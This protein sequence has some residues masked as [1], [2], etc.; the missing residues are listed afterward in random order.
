MCIQS[1]V[2]VSMLPRFFAR[3]WAN[4]LVGLYHS[5]FAVIPAY[6]IGLTILTAED[7]GSGAGSSVRDEL[8]AAILD[9][10]L[11]VIDDIARMQAS[12]NFA[13]T[14]ASSATNSSLTLKA[15]E[16][17]GLKVTAWVSNGVDLFANLFGNINYRI[18]PNGL[19]EGNQVGFTSYYQSASSG[20]ANNN[21]L[22]A[23]QGWF[24]VDEITFG[25]I[26]LG[27]MVFQVD[28][29]GKALS[30]Q[31]RALRITLEKES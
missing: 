7:F 3:L 6:D 29:T 5:F 20:P 22:L 4:C 21:W 13:G 19:Y 16:S 24:A 28:E 2:V 30:V 27:Q 12:T 17:G 10:V 11:P 25:N 15:S 26:P 18:V 31:P 14:Y 1:L 23:C 8:P 9:A